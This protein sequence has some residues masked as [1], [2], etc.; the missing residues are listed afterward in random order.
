[1]TESKKTA[2]ASEGAPSPQPAPASPTTAATEATGAFSSASEKLILSVMM[3]AGRT[4]LHHQ[5]AGLIAEDDLYIEQH[6]ALWR[7]ISTLREAGVPHDPA[8]IM[9]AANRSSTFIGGAPYLMEIAQD[10]TA[11]S[12]SVDSVTAAAGRLKDLS[13]TRR[14]QQLLQRS[15]HLTQTGQDFAT[16]SSYVE[17][18]LVNLRKV[19]SSSRSGP[20]HAAHFY[21]AVAQRIEAK[22]EGEEVNATAP[23]HF[24]LLDE[25]MGGGLPRGG[26]IVIAGRP[27]MGKTAIACAIEQQIS[28]NGRPTLFFS[29]EMPGIALAQRNLSRHSR[30][31]FS[32][33]RKAEIED[34]DYDPLLESLSVL[35]NA[36]CFIDETPGLSMSEI[37][38]R[39]RTFAQTYPDCVIIV[40]Y[41][42]IITASPTDRSD[43]KQLVSNNSK[44]LTLLARE[45]N[46]PVIA[47]AQLNR[48]LETRANKRPVM[49]DLRESGQIE[50]DASLILFVYRDEVYNPDTL[51]KGITELIQGKNR[52]ANPVTIKFA[53]DLSRM[54]YSELGVYG[55]EQ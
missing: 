5:I 35:G 37:R 43:P 48:G 9:D 39:A 41:L 44:A 1:M 18:D 22:A 45:L 42:Q 15:L 7:I 17:D 27:G 47:L 14:L 10:P 50:Q 6:R 32:S 52:D 38:S 26:M 23:T 29:L 36:P 20:V 53:S 12:C 13:N 16:V 31:P 28:L 4:E 8:S 30:I 3:N 19:S 34:R 46:V 49:A 51:D 33:I 55:T 2:A 11:R 24:P 54:L 21:D 40:D 25:S